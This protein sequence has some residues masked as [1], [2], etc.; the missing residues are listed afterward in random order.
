[1]SNLKLDIV[2]SIGSAIMLLNITAYNMTTI[3]IKEAFCYSV[4]KKSLN[5]MI[6]LNSKN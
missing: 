1:M 3:L 2:Q 6:I 4:T 5:K